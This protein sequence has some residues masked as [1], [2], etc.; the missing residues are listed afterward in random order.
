ME[1]SPRHFLLVAL[2]VDS[3]IPVAAPLKVRRFCVPR[4]G[5]KY[6]RASCGSFSNSQVEMSLVAAAAPYAQPVI[7][8]RCNTGATMKIV[9]AFAIATMMAVI[10][11]AAATGSGPPYPIIL[12]HGWCSDSRTGTMWSDFI[13]AV[14]QPPP[15]SSRYGYGVGQF[16]FDGSQVRERDG[17]IPDT[18]DAGTK[19]FT[20]DFYAQGFDPLRV[21][22]VPIEDKAIELKQV[23]DSVKSVTGKDKVILV[24]F[25]MGGLA[26]RAYIQDLA[27]FVTYQNDVE[28]L[29]TLDTPHRGA[30]A[31]KWEWTGVRDSDCRFA[32]TVVK[33]QLR[34]DS[35]FLKQLNSATLPQWSPSRL[36]SIASWVLNGSGQIYGDGVVPY[37]SQDLRTVYS[38]DTRVVTIDNATF[39]KPD[40]VL[41]LLQI[42]Q[43]CLNLGDIF[44]QIH[45]EVYSRA[46]AIARI[47]LAIQETDRLSSGTQMWM[48]AAQGGNFEVSGIGFTGNGLVRLL[49]KR[50]GSSLWLG[51]NATAQTSGRVSWSVGCSEPAGTLVATARDEATWL[52]GDLNGDGI[53]NSIDWS[54][55]NPMWIS[56]D[57][58]A[59]INQDGIVNS[60]DWSI[61]NVNWFKTGGLGRVSPEVRLAYTGC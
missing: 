57:G 24:G 50:P 61:M 1:I 52:K 40:P 29:I 15:S 48:R 21:A 45:T 25:S 12:I 53:V 22:N 49:Y 43:P 7:D 54:M 34:D 31:A 2:A 38:G 44:C 42:N 17:G 26:A 58:L 51:T 59:D 20:I 4:G 46:D 27:G 3:S 19:L 37:V 55:M 13:S 16:Y 9:G 30:P 6:H 8:R 47:R 28:L 5:T 39:P 11:M 35:L 14:Q 36:V 18:D 23:I 10:N 32:P 60:I 33:S 56:N 41:A